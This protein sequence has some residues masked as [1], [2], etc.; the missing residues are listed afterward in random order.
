VEPAVIES[1]SHSNSRR[2]EPLAAQPQTAD[3]R[4]SMDQGIVAS[5]AV[6][7]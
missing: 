7:E 5:T 3:C 4:P 6:E 2:E 1:K